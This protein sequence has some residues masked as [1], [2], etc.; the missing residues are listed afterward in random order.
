MMSISV[1]GCACAICGKLSVPNA[2]IVKTGTWICD[3]CGERIRKLIYQEEEET[4]G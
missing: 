4:D 2:D 3:D 1:I